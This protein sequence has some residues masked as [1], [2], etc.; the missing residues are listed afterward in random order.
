MWSKQIE[1]TGV[2][3]LAALKRWRTMPTES[4]ATLEK[5]GCRLTEELQ[6]QSWKK[7]CWT[8]SCWTKSCK[9]T[10]Q[11]W[12]KSP[13]T[14]GF[15]L[16]FSLNGSASNFKLI[17]ASRC[18]QPDGCCSR[19]SSSNKI[20]TYWVILVTCM[21]M[22]AVYLDLVSDTYHV[23][24]DSPKQLSNRIHTEKHKT[25][26]STSWH[27]CITTVHVTRHSHR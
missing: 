19:G 3:S 18:A 4:Q 24:R 14:A 21:W 12:K 17:V 23:L 11:S 10:S 16:W 5:G 2:A 15:G 22:S 8:K 7:R 13:S 27:I 20:G 6:F 26:L 25:V 9:L 1:Q